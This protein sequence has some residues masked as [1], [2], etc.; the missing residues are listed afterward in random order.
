M[1]RFSKRDDHMEGFV[2]QYQY[3]LGPEHSTSGSLV[4]LTAQLEYLATVAGINNGGIGPESEVVQF[5][6]EARVSGPPS[7]VELKVYGRSAH[8][9]W[10]PPVEPN[11]Y[12]EQ[13]DIYWMKTSPI[14][15]QEKERNW[16]PMDR[17][18]REVKLATSV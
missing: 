15:R 5:M 13:Y 7:N 3:F 1:A 10:N 2:K 16:K 12:I 8:L 11:A 6:T 9:S 18:S 14:D 4:N 17:R